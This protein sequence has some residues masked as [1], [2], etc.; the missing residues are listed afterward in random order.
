MTSSKHPS[1]RWSRHGCKWALTDSG[2]VHAHIVRDGQRWLC[3]VGDPTED[4]AYLGPAQSLEH[5]KAC[6]AGQRLKT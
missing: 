4:D 3:Y 6:L 2:C 1:P 5:A